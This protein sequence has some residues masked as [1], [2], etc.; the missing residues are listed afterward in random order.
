MTPARPQLAALTS[1][2]A[3]G[4]SG[5]RQGRRD[6][7]TRGERAPGFVPVS[8]LLLPEA[9]A[10]DDRPTVEKRAKIDH[11]CRFVKEASDLAQ[12]IQV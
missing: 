11:A 2:F 4:S 12:F 5:R 9:P 3:T 8:D 7:L 1:R 10:Q 6:R